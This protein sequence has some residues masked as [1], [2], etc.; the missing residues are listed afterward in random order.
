MRTRAERR[1]A[2]RYR[3]D[4]LKVSF[5]FAPAIMALGAVLL[6]WTMYW[7]DGR[8]PNEV[9][10]DSHFVL[11]GTVGEMR[12]A[13]LSMGRHRPG[14]RRGGIHTA[15]LAS[16]RPLPPSTARAC[17]VYFWGDRAGQFVLRACL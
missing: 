9:L 8:I 11:S 2:A 15:Y 3:W 14:N 1:V 12:S 13:L 7:I 4:R 17:C 5:W 6:A 16:Y 10:Q